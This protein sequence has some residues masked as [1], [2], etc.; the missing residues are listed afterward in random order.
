M[1][2]ATLCAGIRSVYRNEVCK[3]YTIAVLNTVHQYE[4]SKQVFKL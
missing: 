4:V 1:D 3:A 2:L